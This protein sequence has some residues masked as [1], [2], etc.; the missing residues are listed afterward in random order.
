MFCPQWLW[1][2][3]CLIA[4]VIST[5]ESIYKKM[6]S[7]LEQGGSGIGHEPSQEFDPARHV[8]PRV[9]HELN[10][11]LTIVQG[12][13]DRLFTPFQRLHSERDYAGTGIG[14]ATVHRIVERHGGR[15][16]VEAA[17]GQGATFFF[18]LPS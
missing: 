11:I 17:P 14:H 8:A 6:A 3:R 12:Y 2:A 7:S 5:Y 15:I 1:P 18:T 10:N 16:W 9:A 4:P 13:A